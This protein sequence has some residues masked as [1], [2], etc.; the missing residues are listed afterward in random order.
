VRSPITR[1]LGHWLSCKDASR[2]LSQLQ[3]RRPTGIEAVR[4]RWHLAACDACTRFE[5]QL[6]FLR[7]AMRRFRA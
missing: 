7:D 1:L 3:E 4:L 2:L 5:R 6:A